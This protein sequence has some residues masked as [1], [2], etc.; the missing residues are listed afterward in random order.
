MELVPPEERGLVLAELDANGLT[1]LHCAVIGI[2]SCESN[3]KDEY[4]DIV[5]RLLGYG[6]DADAQSTKGVTPLGTYR[7]AVSGRFMDDNSD[8]EE[9]NDGEDEDDVHV[10]NEMI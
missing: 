6:A 10:D 7:L 1:P 3:D 9:G 2:E 5:E 8:D 4:L